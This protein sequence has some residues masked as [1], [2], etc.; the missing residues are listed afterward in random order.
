MHLLFVKNIEKKLISITHADATSRLQ[1]VRKDQHKLFYD[2]LTVLE[3]VGK[4][5]VILNTSFNIKG[6]PILTTYEDAF[7]VLK[8]TELDFLV[9]E[10]F[11][12]EN[13]KFKLVDNTF[14]YTGTCD[15][16][17]QNGYLALNRFPKHVEWVHE[18]LTTT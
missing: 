14:S 6:K 12:V 11:I 18:D 2:I 3:G 15:L 9:T 8:E 13:E 17:K 5:P 4:I 10:E 1:T 16:G 7:H